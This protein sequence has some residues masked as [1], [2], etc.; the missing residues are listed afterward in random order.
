[1]AVTPVAG[2]GTRL[3][4]LL[5]QKVVNLYSFYRPGCACSVLQMQDCL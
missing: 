3:D 2:L 4:P 1:M 5:V